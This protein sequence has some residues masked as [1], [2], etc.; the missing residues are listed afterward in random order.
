M[1]GACT[2]RFYS[3]PGKEC[4]LQPPSL[5]LPSV[6][7]TLLLLV[8]APP[9]ALAQLPTRTQTLATIELRGGVA[10]QDDISLNG[11]SNTLGAI[12]LGFSMQFGHDY[13]F[14]RWRVGILLDVVPLSSETMFDASLGTD[15]R[16]ED[17]LLIINP[18]IGYDIV[19]KPRLNTTIYFGGAAV[20][21]TRTL[22]LQDRFDVFADVCDVQGFSDRCPEQ[23]NWLGNAGANLRFYPNASQFYVGIDYTRFA[24]GKNSIMGA[25]GWRFLR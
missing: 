21:V 10:H 2:V 25:I 11:K 8:I 22:M 17:D 20:G 23:W 19:R 1:W 6:F 9:S 4:S 24:T 18:R 15:V 7:L 13:R 16:V 12:G 3:V 14:H 5:S